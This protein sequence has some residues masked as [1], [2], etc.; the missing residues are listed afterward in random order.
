MINKC[1]LRVFVGLEW[2]YVLVTDVGT[3]HS[4]PAAAGPG[5]QRL[6]SSWVK[7]FFFRD[8]PE[9]RQKMTTATPYFLVRHCSELLLFFSTENRVNLVIKAVSYILIKLV[10]NNILLPFFMNFFR[11]LVV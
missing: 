4:I 9:K 5:L 8:Q 11:Y 3:L 6:S 1:L 2:Y 10:I 7:I